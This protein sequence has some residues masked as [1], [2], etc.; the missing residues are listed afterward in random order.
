MLAEMDG[1][2]LAEWRAWFE[3]K[4]DNRRALALDAKGKASLA[5]HMMRK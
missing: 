4:D 1:V 5:R 2:E 3:L